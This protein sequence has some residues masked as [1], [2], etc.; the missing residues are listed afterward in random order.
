MALGMVLNE[1]SYPE[2]EKPDHEIR[3]LITQ[4]AATIKAVKAIREDAY[5]VSRERFS[6]ISFGPDS[7]RKFV[8]NPAMKEEILYLFS[9]ANRSPYSTLMELDEFLV[10]CSVNGRQAIGFLYCAISSSF[11]VS[12]CTSEDWN[13]GVIKVI[14][15]EL[16]D[17][18]IQSTFFELLHAA[19]TAH[20][21]QHRSILERMSLERRWTSSEEI[22]LARSGDFPNLVFLP[23]VEHQLQLL[24]RNSEAVA[25]VGNRL[26]ELQVSTAGWIVAAEAF[27]SWMSLVSPEGET[28]KRLT[29][30]ADEAGNKHCYDMHARYTPGPGRIHFRMLREQKQLEIAYIGHKIDG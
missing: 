9:V 15:S 29:M 11:C 17:E 30:F 7:I 1:L 8:G 21:E 14:I 16:S 10:E 25:Q 2:G 28:R 4:L 6:D 13:A 26:V 3:R 19:R 12:F 27:P 5:L 24:P 23:D 18:G 22:W 20:V